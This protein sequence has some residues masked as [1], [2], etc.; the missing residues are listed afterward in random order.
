MMSDEEFEKALEGVSFR[1]WFCPDRRGHSW[2]PDR[3]VPT[4]EWRGDVA[5]CLYPDYGLTS[6]SSQPAGT[7]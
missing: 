1:I 2:P 7:N 4:V 3:V 5:H 6:T